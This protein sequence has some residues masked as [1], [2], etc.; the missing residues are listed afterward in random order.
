MG[1]VVGTAL[2]TALILW[3]LRRRRRR[4]EAQPSPYMDKAGHM[5]AAFGL[6]DYDTSKANK[7][8]VRINTCWALGT[9]LPPAFIVRLFDT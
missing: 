5:A 7:S 3:Y 6:P 2:V 4:A 1:G 8:Y 9:F